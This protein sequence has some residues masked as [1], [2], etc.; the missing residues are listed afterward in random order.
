MPIDI[1]DVPYDESLE[2]VALP[3]GYNHG[4]RVSLA[5][6]AAQ[7]LTVDRTVYVD[8]VA[9]SDTNDGSQ[10]APFQTLARAWAERQRYGVLR[11]KFK[12]QLLGVGP[13]L[14]PPVL[15]FSAADSGGRFVLKGDAN[16]D[17][18]H[19]SGTF[20][21]NFAG[22]TIG[23][24]A[25]LGTDTHKHRFVGITSGPLNG[26][27]FCILKHTDN[28]ITACD[29]YFAS[30]FTITAGTTFKIFSPG[31]VL[32]ATANNRIENWLGG[33][34]AAAVEDQRHIVVRVAINGGISVYDS[35]VTFAA[36]TAS[37]SSSW[38][39][40][41]MNVGYIRDGAAVDEP[42]SAF[43]SASFVSAS[44]T[45][46]DSCV[47]GLFSL[48]NP[49][50]GMT[51]SNRSTVNF[52]AGRVE[53]AVTVNGMASGFYAISG[54]FQKTITIEGAAS[55]G[56]N[57]YTPIEFAVAAGSCIRVRR[58]GQLSWS[59]TAPAGGTTDVNGFG[60]DCS[61][62]GRVILAHAPTLTGGTSGKDL[63]TSN[64]GGVANSVLS[65]AGTAAGVA[66]DALLGEVLC[67]VA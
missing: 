21:G 55:C 34:P 22:N 23:T 31:T 47:E 58:G 2:A 65:A 67:R 8:S 52:Y 3:Y 5:L 27:V 64:N 53:G 57:T 60:I 28:S 18:I 15:G 6:Q 16:A 43:R 29:T 20:S 14:V 32:T 35:L 4:L 66:A 48:S 42:A 59:G 24:S 33:D 54:R 11:A 13:Y 38:R 41:E 50:G 51:I 26:A 19:H 36:S 46:V 30:G 56:W 37:G 9:G 40:S 1:K 62:G 39:G 49:S 12:I 45:I 63:R 17:V 10:A 61:G 44:L 25:G 7:P